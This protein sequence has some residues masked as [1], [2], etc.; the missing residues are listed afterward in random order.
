L[1]CCCCCCCFVFT[2][3]ASAFLATVKFNETGELK[4]DL[5]HLRDLG[6]QESVCGRGLVNCPRICGDRAT[7]QA[8]PVSQQ[9]P[10]NYPQFAPSQAQ[11]VLETESKAAVI[12]QVYQPSSPEAEAELQ[13]QRYPQLPSAILSKNKT[14]TNTTKQNLGAIQL[15]YP[16]VWR[17]FPMRVE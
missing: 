14:K 6:P 7:G 2:D 3:L 11:T 16:S 13:I 17:G 10:T 9:H 12:T 1:F 5:T 15:V 4:R 8:A